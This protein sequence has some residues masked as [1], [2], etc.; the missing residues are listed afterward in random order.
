MKIW[1]KKNQ[2]MKNGEHI[3]L[4]QTLKSKLHFPMKIVKIL[5][6]LLKIYL[7]SKLKAMIDEYSFH[8]ENSIKGEHKK[9]EENIKEK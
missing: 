7:Q 1:K 3:H 2:F 4:F 9:L 5:K 6:N 8:L